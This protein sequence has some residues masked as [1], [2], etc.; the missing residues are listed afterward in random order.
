MKT[1]IDKTSFLKRLCSAL[2][3]ALIIAMPAAAKK[4]YKFDT[5]HSYSVM[6]INSAKQGTVMVKAWAV[7]KNP[8]KAIEQAKMDAVAAILF[9]GANP[10]PRKAG[11]GISG[12]RALSS[13]TDY[14]NHKEFFD[15]FFTSG[16]FM[17]Y[18]Q[19]INA[20]YPSGE[21]NIKVPKGRKVGINLI[22]LYDALRKLLEENGIIE[23]LDSHFQIN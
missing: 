21:N 19:D 11:M 10:D 3:L 22:I 14:M 6:Q 1:Q 4:K 23:S 13:K 8:D 18:V 5:E 9:T 17:M 7:D 20:D 16:D 2:M 12:V 15:N